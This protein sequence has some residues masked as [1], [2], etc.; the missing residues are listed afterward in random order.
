M[1]KITKTKDI[2]NWHKEMFL[3]KVA[4]AATDYAKETIYQPELHEDAVNSVFQDFMEGASTAYNILVLGK[5][6]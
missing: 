1:E 6:K 3:N 5:S 4:E 2:S